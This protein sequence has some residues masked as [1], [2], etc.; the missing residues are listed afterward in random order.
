[1]EQKMNQLYRKIAEIID[2]MIPTKWDD[3]IILMV[4]CKME[5]GESSFSLSLRLGATMF[6]LLI[7]QMYTM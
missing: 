4:K 2:Q 3:F 6:I 5:K 1:M 7:F